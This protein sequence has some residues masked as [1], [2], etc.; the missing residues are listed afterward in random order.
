MS[1]EKPETDAAAERPIKLIVERRADP[2]VNCSARVEV[3]SLAIDEDFD[4]GCDPYNR[5]GQFMA[6]RERDGE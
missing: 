4:L 2:A 5:T 3:V 6:L 1:S